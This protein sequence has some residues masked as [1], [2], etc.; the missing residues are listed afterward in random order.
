MPSR[1][2]HTTA[3]HI[4]QF[5]LQLV[6]ALQQAAGAFGHGRRAA[7]AALV[8]LGADLHL[9]HEL[10]G[11]SASAGSSGAGRT[12]PS[13]Q[14]PLTRTAPPP[15]PRLPTPEAAGPNKSSRGRSRP[16]AWV[17]DPA[18]GRR[19]PTPF[20]PAPTIHSKDVV[21]AARDVGRARDNSGRPKGSLYLPDLSGDQAGS[22]ESRESLDHRLQIRRSQVPLCCLAFPMK[23][24]LLSHVT[25]LNPLR[26][27]FSRLMCQKL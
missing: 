23:G 8:G 12:S 13:P 17:G 5:Q 24:L 7:E 16:H 15:P 11:S 21:G 27:I 6:Q 3:H 14:A 22:G 9:G 1:L 25:C 10:R 18:P 4:G 20:L 2:F 26:M 19:G